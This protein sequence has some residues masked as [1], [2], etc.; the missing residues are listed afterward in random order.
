MSE[1]S[2]QYRIEMYSKELKKTFDHKFY[3]KPSCNYID[4]LKQF[5]DILES[6]N[7]EITPDCLDAIIIGG[8]NPKE[9][10]ILLER[11]I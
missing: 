6:Y 3:I 5:V 11:V 9:Q 1:R 2:I 7:L 8:R 4:V 10:K